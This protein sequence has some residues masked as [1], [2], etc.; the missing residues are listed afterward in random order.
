MR[1]IM[2]YLAADCAP[3]RAA[4]RVPFFVPSQC[5][6][7]NQYTARL[8]FCPQRRSASTPNDV[9][10]CIT[11]PFSTDAKQSRKSD[12]GGDWRPRRRSIKH[13]LIVVMPASN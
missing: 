13:V 11:A 1:D 8:C 4:H 2:F 7:L 6:L 3:S 9:G 5:P 10:P 12:G